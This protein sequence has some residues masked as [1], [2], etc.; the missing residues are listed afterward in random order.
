ML[1][2][3][4]LR[5][6][7][8]DWPRIPQSGSKAEFLNLQTAERPERAIAIK[9]SIAR[10][11]HA[12]V[13]LGRETLELSADVFFQSGNPGAERCAGRHRQH[14]TRGSGKCHAHL[15]H[16]RQVHGPQER[17]T[18]RDKVFWRGHS[19]LANCTQAYEPFIKT[20]SERFYP[21]L[22]PDKTYS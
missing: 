18:F 17:S 16:A 22:H 9:G 14:P 1:D 7:I 19:V 21:N 20:Y 6:W 13:L 3:C 4:R 8:E 11:L 12:M 2:Y 15:G 5:W 10:H